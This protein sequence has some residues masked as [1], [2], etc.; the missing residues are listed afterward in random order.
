MPDYCYFFVDKEDHVRD[1]QPHVS[2]ADD[3]TAVRVAEGVL[4]EKLKAERWRFVAVEIWDQTR[5]VAR[6][7]SIYQPV[8][9]EAAFRRRRAAPARTAPHREAVA[10]P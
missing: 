9:E 5:K 8:G 7:P 3:T 1:I 2:C 10:P 4:A 6:R